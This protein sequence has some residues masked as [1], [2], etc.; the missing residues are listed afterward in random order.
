MS[1]LIATIILI[2][3]ILGILVILFRRVPNLV[4][5]SPEIEVSQPGPILKTKNEIV[6]RFQSFSFNNFLRKFLLRFKI[7]TQKAENK[8]SSLIEKLHQK[9]KKE[10]E[11]SLDDSSD[12]YWK[13]LKKK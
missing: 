6:A 2:V 7:F 12:D 4:K 3:S 9:A 10:E 1:I 5:S 8:I 11:E 13:Q